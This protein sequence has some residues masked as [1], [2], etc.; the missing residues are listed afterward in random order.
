MIDG[1]EIN[2]LLQCH[3]LVVLLE[4]DQSLALSIVDLA[5][6]RVVQTDVQD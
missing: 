6:A 1:N 5:L 3:G 4:V 2:N